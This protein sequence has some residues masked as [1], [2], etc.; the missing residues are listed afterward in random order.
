MDRIN[1]IDKISPKPILMHNGRFDDIV[2]AGSAL[3]F[4]TKAKEP[5][6]RSFSITPS[7]MR[8]LI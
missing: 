5:K 8:L 1:F 4:F 3:L 2:P 7:T 6:E